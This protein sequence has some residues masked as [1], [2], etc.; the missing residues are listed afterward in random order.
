LKKTITA[1]TNLVFSGEKNK[2]VYLRKEGSGK[3][4]WKIQEKFGRGGI[5]IAN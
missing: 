2:L 3:D 1:A 4:T 5:L